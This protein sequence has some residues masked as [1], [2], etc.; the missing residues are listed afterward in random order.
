MIRPYTCDR[1]VEH[2]SKG[3]NI[4]RFSTL[5]VIDLGSFVPGCASSRRWVSFEDGKAKVGDLGFPV[6][7]W[8]GIGGQSAREPE[9]G[10]DVETYRLECLRA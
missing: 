7:I 5:T 10:T 9:D 2:H 8:K 6:G 4:G 1:L 3:E